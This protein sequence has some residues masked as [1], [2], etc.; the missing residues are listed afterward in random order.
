MS[1]APKKTVPILTAP[2]IDPGMARQELEVPEGLSLAQM[3]EHAFPG[4]S[5]AN[6]GALRVVLVTP[7]G[8]AAIDARYW[9]MT[10]PKPGVQV[11]IRIVPG[12]ESLRS[13]LLAVVTVAAFALTGPLAGALGVGASTFGT[14]LVRAGL[15]IVGSLLV[16]AL[17]PMPE[18]EQERQ[19]NSYSISGWQN[20]ARPNEAL[21]EV[22]GRHRVAPPFAARSYSEI[23]GDQQFIRALFCLGVGP[24]KISDIRIGNTSIDEYKDVEIEIREGY[25][26]D[27]PLTLYP[28]QVLEDSEGA[29][30]VRPPQYDDAGEVIAGP[31][32]ETPVVR[33]T[34]A[35]TQDVNVI[36]QFPQGLHAYDD[37][38][39]RVGREITIRIRQRLK[40]DQDWQDVATLDI[41]GNE[42]SSMFRQHRW[43]MPSRGKWEIEITRMSDDVQDT[44]A[45]STVQ[46]AAL[47]SIRP[48]YPINMDQ[49][50]ALFAV[51]VR[52]THQLNGPLDSLN[53]IAERIGR[54][55]DGTAWS[56]GTS[57]NPAAAFVGLLQSPSNP[58][59][60]ADAEVDWDGLRDW[61][62]W[63]D[64]KGLK[65]DR[66]LEGGLSFRE[67]ANEI[68][69]AG[70][71][72]HR[73]DGVRWG[74]VIDR[75]EDLVVDHISPRNSG[76]FS[77]S[78]SYFDPP[79]AFRVRFRD[80]TNDYAEAERIIPWPDHTGDITITEEIQLPGKTDPREI[81]I[82]ARRRM[83][84]LMHRPDTFTT[85]QSGA[86]RVATRGD[87][88]MGSYDVLSHQ[89]QDARVKMIEGSLVELD[90]VI[91]AEDDQ[92][93]AIRFR[94]FAHENDVIGAS[95][96][97]PVTLPVP[98]APLLALV[99]DGP[100]PAVGELVHIGPYTKVSEP[101]KI[102]GV[103][104]GTS[105]TSTLTLIPAAPEIDELTD[106]EVPPD[107]TGR[108]G[109]AIVIA[110]QTP[111][112]PRVVRIVTE[113]Q[114]T[115][116]EDPGD[117]AEPAAT[118]VTM[119]LAPAQGGGVALNGYRV[120]HRPQTGGGWA[121]IDVPAASARAT[122]TGYITEDEIE[123][124]AYAVSYDG[125]ESDPT[126][127]LPV[128]V[129]GTDVQLP[130]AV[131][132]ASVMIEGG[133]GHAKLTLA[134]PA[135]PASQVIVYR[136]PFG[137]ALDRDAHALAAPV[138][139]A[140]GSTVTFTDGDATRQNLLAD[141]S[142]DGAGWTLGT[143]WTVAG[144]TADHADGTAGDLSQAIALD[145]GETYNF[146]TDVG[147]LS[148]G[149]LTPK[150][151]GATTQNGDAINAAGLE[152]QSLVV[153]TG[154][155]GF[156]IG[157]SAACV[158][159]LTEAA[160][161]LATGATLSPCAYT[162]YLEPKTD[163]GLP[164]S[165]S[166]PFSVTVR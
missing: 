45:G 6:H 133:L 99:G 55:W 51:R 70:R 158:A 157:A 72:F 81:W 38:G 161:Y 90:Q 78:R 125:T 153:P 9:H 41:W 42:N 75:P 147:T 144:G 32:V 14:A 92:A 127:I 59:P 68:C 165:L 69:A 131:E 155:T 162:Y 112:T 102:R 43:Q 136:V 26:G 54:R 159:S 66:E 116:G 39:R 106:A 142:F 160:L 121:S 89:Q 65:Y 21:P 1:K 8:A 82:E 130:Q 91:E 35:D 156:A 108:V 37:K 140:T 13:V 30:L 164:G 11:V 97:R 31:N 83:Y 77:W 150:L 111:P 123:L 62:E 105:F 129:G 33:E 23:V 57:R 103:E 151:T 52:A 17:V 76:G 56:E 15:T 110:N 80:E 96:V 117:P 95:V 86:A 28:Q 29:E 148:G 74:V 146:S 120:E 24:V 3:V 58:F 109:S 87:L 22:F 67:L 94:V 101:M 141:P 85:S 119:H 44:P 88:V 4:M 132:D 53:V 20:T 60:V 100:L 152:L 104:S 107:W 84:E 115:G 40:G 12:K 114:Y 10:R 149:S 113:P 73:H 16:N 61:H 166:G 63:C 46:L 34:A 145:E 122:I 50:L 139:G 79:H 135:A 134:M 143:D 128:D 2:L 49:P 124:R 48:E 98:D 18:P 25:P 27:A 118:T 138:T 19:K 5:R 71:A 93:M 47:Q 163:A 137:Q 36:L 64:A 126:P 7:I 154:Q